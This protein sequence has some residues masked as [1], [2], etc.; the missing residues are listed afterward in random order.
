MAL[1][2]IDRL[3]LASLQKNARISNKELAAIAGVAQSTCL[4]RLRRLRE[5]GVLRG[6]HAAVD[7]AQLGRP[8][9]AIVSVRLRIHDRSQIDAFHEHALELPESLAVF[10]VTGAD[11]YLIHAAV[12]DTE[13]LRGLVLDLTARPE[14]DHVET[15]LIFDFVRK[16]VIDPI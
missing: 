12:R 13:H 14:V 16:P 2:R 6:F 3:L 4:E 11:D 7:L 5:R 9:Q 10:H 8:T 1:D 15:S